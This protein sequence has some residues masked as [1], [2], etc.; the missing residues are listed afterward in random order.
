[1]NTQQIREQLLDVCRNFRHNIEDNVVFPEPYIPYI[2]DNWNGVLVLCESQNLSKSSGSYYEL[3]K[4]WSSDQRLNRLYEEDSKE[5]DFV[6]VKPWDEGTLKLA[7]EAA[8]YDDLKAHQCAVSNSVMWSITNESRSKNLNPIPSMKKE[9]SRLWDEMFKV[10]EPEKI[11]TV[12]KVA[13]TVIDDTDFKNRNL[14]L[15]SS[16]SSFVSRIAGMFP[17]ED[18]LERYPVVKLVMDKHPEWKDKYIKNKIFYAC[19]AVSM[20]SCFKKANQNK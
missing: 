16:S 14:A 10:F 20:A 15:R 2:P 9:S 8:F 18:L 6:G 3:L 13:R 1:M 7:V 11:I 5:R 19:H 17:S 4:S 12:G